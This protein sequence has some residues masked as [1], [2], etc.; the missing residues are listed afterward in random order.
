M[1]EEDEKTRIDGGLVLGTRRRRYGRVRCGAC[2]KGREVRVKDGE[3]MKE[4][5]G[6]RMEDVLE[7]QR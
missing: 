1:S 5:R 3:V 6:G 2:A 7:W 4:G